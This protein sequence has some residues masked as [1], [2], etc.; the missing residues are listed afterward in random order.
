MSNQ[1]VFVPLTGP[2]QVSDLSSADQSSILTY[3]DSV[4]HTGT[5]NIAF[6]LEDDIVNIVITPTSSISADY[7]ANTYINF[8]GTKPAFDQNVI[9]RSSGVIT[10][11]GAA[12]IVF[13]PIMAELTLKTEAP[14]VSPA[15]L[16]KQLDLTTTS[17]GDLKSMIQAWSNIPPADQIIGTTAL[18]PISEGTT[19]TDSTFLVDC[20]VYQDNAWQYYFTAAGAQVAVLDNRPLSA[21][22]TKV[23]TNYKVCLYYSSWGIYERNFYPPAVDYSRVTH[24]IYAFADIAPDTEHPEPNGNVLPDGTVYMP[25]INDIRANFKALDD[26]RSKY[27]HLKTI[28]SI[29]GWTYSVN[30]SDVA[31]DA[32]KTQ[33]FVDS[34]YDLMTNYNFDGLDIDWE[35]PV[36]GGNNITHR[37]ADKQ[38]FTTL[39]QALRDKIGTDKLLTIAGPARPKFHQNIEVEKIA[40]IVDW[41][42]LMA[43]DF[44]GPWM[45]TENAV[46]NFNAPLYADYTAPIPKGI[47]HDLNI[48]ASVRSLLTLNL[49]PE[50]LVLGLSFYGRAFSGVDPGPNNDGLYQA[51]TGHPNGTWPDEK[52]QASA[53]FDYWDLYDN[54]IGKSG[55]KSYYNHQAGAA[56]LYNADQKIFIGYD[57]PQTIYNKCAY[58]AAMN[59][60]GAMIWEASND[61]YNQ[62]LYVANNTLNEGGLQA[63]GQLVPEAAGSTPSWS[64]AALSQNGALKLTKIM[65]AKTANGITG[66]KT[67]YG[68]AEGAWH[69]LNEGI[70]TEVIIPDSRFIDRL[71]LY[72]GSGSQEVFVGLGFQMDNRTYIALGDT[73]NISQMESIGAESSRM[74]QF[75][76]TVQN[77]KLVQ[78]T[79]NF[80]QGTKHTAD[81]F[82][83]LQD[84]PDSQFEGTPLQFKMAGGYAYAGHYSGAVT[85]D[86]M[87]LSM[88]S[89]GVDTPH[90]QITAGSVDF[91]S[92]VSVDGGFTYAMGM[93]FASV[94]SSLKIGDPDDP[95]IQI[96]YE[97]PSFGFYNAVQ[98]QKGNLSVG[99][100]DTLIDADFAAGN[101]GFT[102]DC[103]IADG[104][105]ET[106]EI[107]SQHF[108]IAL[109]GN[110]IEINKSGIG[111]FFGYG[112][113]TITIKLINPIVLA[114]HL[115]EDLYKIGKAIWDASFK[116]YL[117]FKN[118]VTGVVKAVQDV[119]NFLFG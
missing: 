10:A 25:D 45:G 12:V 91:T 114:E 22:P 64:D 80:D 100:H 41:V 26:I 110:G 40:N 63:D 77:G 92:Q 2:T 108:K 49:P 48:D 102:M 81:D 3:V 58:L 79:A 30:F 24:L 56:W 78:L 17:L 14:G 31:A 61:R 19:N 93:Q 33:R 59:L 73:S 66:I 94:E 98:Y 75:S 72:L 96:D 28:L 5:S 65:V 46:T 29:G 84:V 57:N 32:T 109:D 18:G 47:T 6:Q 20:K 1:K 117:A 44:H 8:A 4:V 37:P 99:L 86:G 38:N 68:S 82:E 113:F 42:N 87:E 89:I 119:M 43:Y 15:S 88:Q 21:Q 105:S 107:D 90:V 97:G 27:P 51:Y 7:I 101:K 112:P 39:L 9:Y 52:G 53:V 69:G 36:E 74:R 16:S 83:A 23:P 115:L 50:K 13:P 104:F 11:V 34:A 67:T 70:R 111:F 116:I 106:L 55:W 71:D 118:F 35:I 62:L 103:S 54:Y 95:A 76:G 85:T 60:G